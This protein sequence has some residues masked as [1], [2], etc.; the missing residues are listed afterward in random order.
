V[1]RFTT[2][3]PQR[4]IGYLQVTCACF[5]FG[6]EA[7]CAPNYGS[8]VQGQR[9]VPIEL[10]DVAGLV[11]GAHEGKGLGNKFLDDLRKADALIHVVDVSGTTDA[12][13]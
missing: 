6:L 7:Q 4:A 11:P 9:S 12:E 8:C 10:I 2:I 3:D 13:G 1:C 5:R